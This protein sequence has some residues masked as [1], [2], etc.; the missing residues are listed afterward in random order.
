MLP[1]VPYCIRKWWQYDRL[2]LNCEISLNC[3]GYVSNLIHSNNSIRPIQNMTH[4]ILASASWLA[5]VLMAKHMLQL[6]TN[7]EHLKLILCLCLYSNFVFF[8]RLATYFPTELDKSSNSY[9]LEQNTVLAVLMFFERYLW[10]TRWGFFSV[11]IT[12]QRRS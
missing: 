4:G 12:S 10:R 2:K 5:I 6:A 1:V 7:M 3:V 11:F 9:T 8:W